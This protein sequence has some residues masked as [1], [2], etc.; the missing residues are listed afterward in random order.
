MNYFQSKRRFLAYFLLLTIL[1]AS[2]PLTKTQAASDFKIKKGVLISYSGK[3]AKLTIPKG[4]TAIGERA[5]AD[6]TSL[7]SVTIPKS[8]KSIGDSAFSGCTNLSTITIPKTIT[9][10]GSFAF[11]GTKWLKNQQKKDSLVIVN[12]I[13]ITGS[14]AK[15]KVKKIGRAS[16][17]ERV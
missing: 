4:V 3:K 6:C 2:L 15:G 12:Q 16:C 8:V 13:L 11:S 7:K 5:F 1:C 17:R 9:S 14:T 10:I